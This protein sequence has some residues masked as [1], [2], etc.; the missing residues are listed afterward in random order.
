MLCSTFLEILKNNKLDPS[1][2][3]G[4]FYNKL[5]QRF[6]LFKLDSYI[7]LKFLQLDVVEFIVKLENMY[8]VGG[9]SIK[10]LIRFLKDIKPN[11]YSF[12]KKYRNKIT[13]L[14]WFKLTDNDIDDMINEL[15][16]ML[17]K[18]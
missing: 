1:K 18:L 10:M 11:Y 13:H 2:N 17:K 15:I 4:G 14:G 6:H 3:E 8:L 7:L 9:Y 16:S 5:I 12:I